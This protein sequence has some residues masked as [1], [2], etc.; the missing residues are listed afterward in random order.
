MPEVITIPV[1]AVTGDNIV[2]LET[3]MLRGPRPVRDVRPSIHHEDARALDEL[4]AKDVARDLMEIVMDRM[5]SIAELQRLSADKAETEATVKVGAD[6][7]FHR[8]IPLRTNDVIL[9]SLSRVR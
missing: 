3:A 1:S 7:A 5:Q 9:V 8:D 6:G 4:G 2:M